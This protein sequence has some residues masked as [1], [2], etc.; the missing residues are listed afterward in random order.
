M[1]SKH[2]NLLSLALAARVSR[3]YTLSLGRADR[4]MSETSCALEDI[5]LRME[6]RPKAKT[7]R[8]RE[9]RDETVKAMDLMHENSEQIISFLISM[10]SLSTEMVA[11]RDHR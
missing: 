8:R 5:P 11:P 2:A 7:C 1:V 6:R 4:L 10:G 9:P 3:P